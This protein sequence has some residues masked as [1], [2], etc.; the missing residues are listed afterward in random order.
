MKIKL[1]NS[2]IKYNE[3]FNLK[4]DL[5]IQWIESVIDKINYTSF[6]FCKDNSDKSSLCNIVFKSPS[7]EDLLR[8]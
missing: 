1:L 4:I 2:K 8:R 5:H 6:I 3:V 7:K